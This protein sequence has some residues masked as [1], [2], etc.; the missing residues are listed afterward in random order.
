MDTALT[1][2]PL[3]AEALA[4]LGAPPDLVETPEG[5]VIVT[6][7]RFGPVRLAAV[8]RGPALSSG[9]IAA[10]RRR[11]VRFCE[12]DR[13]CDLRGA[14]FG[15]ITTAA[16]VAELPLAGSAAARRARMAGKWRNRLRQ[17]EGAGLSL[18]EMAFAG[19]A[20]DW[21]AAQEG[22]QRRARGYRA[23]P[24]DIARAWAAAD[25]AAARMFVAEADGIRIAA[26][27]FLIHGSGA[28]YHI[29]WSGPAGRA[30]SAHHLIL[31]QAADRL[32]ER[33]VTRIDLGI[34]DTDGT[35]GLA[36]FKIGAGADVRPLGGS[37]IALPGLGLRRAPH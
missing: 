3:F 24:V 27:L 22:A 7:R 28:S 13:P 35:P 37:W 18:R 21:L 25:P 14:G 29:G 12:P 20:A 34:V 23:L 31:A 11:G 5:R 17:A 9:A 33:G 8:L 32:A 1:Q 26:M 4:R 16:H 15:L 2:H 6:Y 36:R 19:P 10:L 30:V